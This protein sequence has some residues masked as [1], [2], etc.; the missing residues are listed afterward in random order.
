MRTP[1]LKTEAAAAQYHIRADERPS[2]YAA[3]LEWH[4][5]HSRPGVVRFIEQNGQLIAPSMM[6]G[7]INGAGERCRVDRSRPS[8]KIAPLGL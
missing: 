7:A 2:E 5:R 8:R 1:A 6:P 3:W 4:R